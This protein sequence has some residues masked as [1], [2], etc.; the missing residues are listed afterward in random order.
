MQVDDGDWQPATLARAISA[1]TWVQWSYRWNAAPGSHTVTVRATS[2]DGEV[3]TAA[4]A[5]VAP[6]GATGHHTV[7]ISVIE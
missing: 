5:G 3:Q 6:D 2:V 4:P 7:S 1:D